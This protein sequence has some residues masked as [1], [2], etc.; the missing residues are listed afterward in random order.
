MM[1]AGWGLIESKDSLWARVL[2]AKY[3]CGNDIIP[4]VERRRSDSNLWKGICLAW[5]DV[6][7]NMVWRVGDGSQIK[8]WTHN[9]IP[10]IGR[11]SQ[12]T[13]QVNWNHTL[14]V[15]NLVADILAKKGQSM[16]LDLHILEDSILDIFNA[17]SSDCMG[18]LRLRG[19]L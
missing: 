3:K 4:Q 8:F 9:W 6:E 17:L 13:L 11:L 18:S 14:R 7:K 12:Q 2:R 5:E 1:K 16:S 19:T 15:A 10:N